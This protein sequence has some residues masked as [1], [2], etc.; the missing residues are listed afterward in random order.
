M[1]GVDGTQPAVEGDHVDARDAVGGQPEGAAQHP[2][3][4][5]EDEPRGPGRSGR[6]LH[7]GKTVRAAAS[8]RSRMRAP[9]PTVATAWPGSMAIRTGGGC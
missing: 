1:F 2:Q 7:G 5:A 6:S 8:V 4:A 3:P 9:A